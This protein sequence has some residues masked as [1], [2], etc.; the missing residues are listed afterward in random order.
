MTALRLDSDDGR[1]LG[2]PMPK[3]VFPSPFTPEPILH[4]IHDPDGS[5]QRAM[6]AA[7]DGMIG[8]A[9]VDY[10]DK[11]KAHADELA[12]YGLGLGEVDYETV[13]DP[14]DPTKIRYRGTFRIVPLNDKETR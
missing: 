3:P 9:Y 7:L 2:R 14:D 12:E 8:R 11:V 5:R 6:S 1:D 10:V 4:L 13:I